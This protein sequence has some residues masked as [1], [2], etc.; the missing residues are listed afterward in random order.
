MVFIRFS[1]LC[2]VSLHCTM[3]MVCLQHVLGEVI[4]GAAVLPLRTVPYKQNKQYNPHYVV[5]QPADG[6]Y[7]SKHVT[8]IVFTK[9]ITL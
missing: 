7:K 2:D 5:Q 8:I 1:F 3:C 6:P 9:T 4:V